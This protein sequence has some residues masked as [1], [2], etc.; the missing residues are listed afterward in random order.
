MSE[1]QTTTTPSLSEG[2]F[3]TPAGLEI[4][5][6]AV[7]SGKVS[8]RDLS[9]M[10]PKNA[11]KDRVILTNA[12]TWFKVYLFQE[13]VRV[14]TGADEVE[15]RRNRP[16]FQRSRQRQWNDNSP[17]TMPPNLHL[18]KENVDLDVL[19]KVEDY[20]PYSRGDGMTSYINTVKN[21]R[22]IPLSEQL[23]LGKEIKENDNLEARNKLIEHNLRLVPWVAKRYLGRGLDLND[24][25]QEGNIGLIEAAERFDYTLGYTFSTYALWWI[26]QKIRNAIYNHGSTIRLPVGGWETRFKILDA[27]KVLSPDPTAQLPTVEEVAAH[28]SLPTSRVRSVIDFFD[29][30]AVYLDDSATS[31]KN[32]KVESSYGDSII[33]DTAHFSADQ[34][35]EAKEELEFSLRK[36]RRLLEV[37]ETLSFGPHDDSERNRDI[38]RV[39]YGLNGTFNHQSLD[40]VGI[41]FNLTRERVRQ[42]IEIIWIKLDEAGFLM[43]DNDLEKEFQRIKAL[44]EI[45]G[46]EAGMYL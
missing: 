15:C 40:T 36:I 35:I 29:L 24:L 43:N 10:L 4:F 16:K 1:V 31:L 17:S 7:N 5:N 3:L 28:L 23:L 26:K 30:K 8:T 42:I 32:D 46:I 6:T 38:F 33:P 14:I 18:L 21:S 20:L 2:K 27:Y 34:T 12:I 11:L 13:N 44:E 41:R 22:L 25:I 39:R 45:V 37:L 9:L 19:D